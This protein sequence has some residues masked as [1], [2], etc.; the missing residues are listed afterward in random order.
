MLLRCTFIIHC[1]YTHAL[2]CI[3]KWQLVLSSC[4]NRRMFKRF[5]YFLSHSSAK[6]LRRLHKIISCKI[7]CKATVVLVSKKCSSLI[8][9]H[10]CTWQ[11]WSDFLSCGGWVIHKQ[12][13][14]CSIFR[15]SVHSF[16]NYC[17]NPKLKFL[18]VTFW[19][20]PSI[21]ICLFCDSQTKLLRNLKF[22]SRCILV[23]F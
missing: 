6:E 7:I 8:R 15:T 11:L 22:G 4:W 2:I 10:R 16:F 17:L 13:Y 9:K 5:I 23:K 20:I 21:L 12:R 3:Q 18:S 14:A 1:A 19:S